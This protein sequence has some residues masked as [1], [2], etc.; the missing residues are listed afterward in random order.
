MKFEKISDT[1]DIVSFDFT[2]PFC[3]KKYTVKKI[4]KYGKSVKEIF[5]TCDYKFA[6]YGLEDHDY[7]ALDYCK[8]LILWENCDSGLEYPDVIND[9]EWFTR[10]S[11]FP[12]RI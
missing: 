10:M 8:H 6:T 7:D 2:C 4:W 9:L 11:G 5:Y 3:S 1:E 12:F